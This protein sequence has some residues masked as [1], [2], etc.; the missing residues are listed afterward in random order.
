MAF[1][2]DAGVVA[3]RGSVLAGPAGQL[4]PVKVGSRIA[5]GATV[6][7]LDGAVAILSFADDSR[8]KLNEKTEVTIHAVAGKQPRGVDL[9]TGALFAMISKH[10]KQS[11]QVR[12]PV[13]VAGVRGT[14]FFTSYEKNAWM[15]VQ[16]GQVEMTE[17]EHPKPVLVNAGFGVVVEKGKEIAPPKQYEWTK[18]LNWNM[19][20][21]AGEI[22]D[23]SKIGVEHR[24]NQEYNRD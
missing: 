24:E 14:K 15:C 8:L 4:K 21:N 13:A 7:T 19:D 18:H 16:E 2:D 12:T 10:P 5:D 11:F 1:A 9:V 20:P 17:L 3:A 23:K 6:K 22:A